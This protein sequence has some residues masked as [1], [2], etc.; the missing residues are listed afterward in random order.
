MSWSRPARGPTRR[1]A[2]WNWNY[3]IGLSGA[4]SERATIGSAPYPA[5][6]ICPSRPMTRWKGSMRHFRSPSCGRSSTRAADLARK[7]GR[8]CGFLKFAPPRESRCAATILFESF[9]VA[10]SL[11]CLCRLYE[12]ATCSVSNLYPLKS[13]LAAAKRRIRDALERTSC[14]RNI[15][16]FCWCREAGRLAKAGASGQRILCAAFRTDGVRYRAAPL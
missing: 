4:S 13:T 8:R 6:R 15:R 9:F 5:N 12:D 7:S 11:T 16:C 14:W 10:A 3:Q 1:Y 2:C